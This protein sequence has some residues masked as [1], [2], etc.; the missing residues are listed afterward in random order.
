[1]KTPFEPHPNFTPE[2][3]DAIARSEAEG[4]AYLNKLAV[5]KKLIVTTKHH[6]FT[7]ERRQDGLWIRGHEKYCPEFIPVTI[8]GSTF[9]HEGSMIR[10]GFLGIGMYMEFY[11]ESYM[12]GKKRITT[13]S[14]LDVV[15]E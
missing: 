5:G 8:P 7:I 13:S 14:I 11:P 2:V 12:G 15:E 3:N 4:G 10:L 9:A 6:V 1:M